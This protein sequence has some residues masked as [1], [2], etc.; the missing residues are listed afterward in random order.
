VLSHLLC[1]RLLKHLWALAEFIN[2]LHVVLVELELEE[3][4]EDVVSLL[5]EHLLL[6]LIRQPW[7]YRTL[8]LLTTKLLIYA[9]F[10]FSQTSHTRLQ[11]LR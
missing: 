7:N 1:D 3:A 5:H 10:L 11:E 2:H 6:L 8:A 4:L 9:E